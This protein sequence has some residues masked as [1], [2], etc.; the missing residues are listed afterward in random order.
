MTR[1][2]CTSADVT[3]L[4][5]GKSRPAKSGNFRGVALRCGDTTAHHRRR[6]GRQHGGFVRRSPRRPGHCRRAG[7]DRRRGASPRLHPVEDDDRHRRSDELPPPLGGNGT[8]A[9]VG[10]GRHGSV[11][12]THRRD[13]GPPAHGHDR[14]A[15]EPKRA[16]DRR[17]GALRDAARGRGRHDR[18]DRAGRVRRRTRVDGLAAAHPRL[19]PARTATASSRRATATRRRSSRAAS[20]SSA[21]GS[22]VWSSCTCSPRSAPR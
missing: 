18:R 1:D 7:S 2:R 6:P 4:Q 9:G 8:G 5:P 13:Q 3:A 11:D 19:V 15:A 21:Q 16:A 17:H 10:D 12:R 20:R 22:P 14:T